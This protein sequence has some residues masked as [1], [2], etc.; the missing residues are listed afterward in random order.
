M[1]DE[2]DLLK[3]GKREGG[4]TGSSGERSTYNA[5]Q[6]R[7]GSVKFP[8]IEFV[9]KVNAH[10]PRS[11]LVPKERDFPVAWSKQSDAHQLSSASP[12]VRR[13]AARA[14]QSAR[15]ALGKAASHCMDDICV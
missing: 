8:V 14:S 10:E 12:N 9:S 4:H 15:R 5:P 7:V 13:Y 1:R 2:I 6:R 11:S 3:V